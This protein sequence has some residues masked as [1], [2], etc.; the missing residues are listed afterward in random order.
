[1]DEQAL[2]S[3]LERYDLITTMI[4]NILRDAGIPE[5][6]GNAMIPLPQR[7]RMLVAERDEAIRRLQAR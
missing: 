4:R 5:T 6:Q 7:V 2:R 3:A 1:M